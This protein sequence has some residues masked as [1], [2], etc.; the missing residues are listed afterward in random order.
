MRVRRPR[1]TDHHSPARSDPAAWA[2]LAAVLGRLIA[3][4]HRARSTTPPRPPGPASGR[5]SPTP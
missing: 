4:R 5:S 1:R 2:R 3:R